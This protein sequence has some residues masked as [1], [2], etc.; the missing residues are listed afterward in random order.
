MKFK[1][2]GTTGTTGTGTVLP[3][4]KGKN[5]PKTGGLVIDSY[6][7][8]A[9]DSKGHSA[10]VGLRV[11]PEMRRIVAELVQSGRF[12]WKTD[13]DFW[14]WAGYWGAEYAATQIGD[15]EKLNYIQ[16]Q[17]IIM[18]VIAKRNELLQWQSD[19]VEMEKTFDALMREEDGGEEDAIQMLRDAQ[20]EIEKIEDDTWRRRWQAKF[21]KRF[22]MYLHNNRKGRK[23]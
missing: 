20:D 13:S 11:I 21:D 12:P 6:E 3:I 7:V 16:R 1:G 14:R 18:S 22:G 4:I 8:P 23:R 15:T 5:K 17:R 9:Q 10:R 19:F 2:T